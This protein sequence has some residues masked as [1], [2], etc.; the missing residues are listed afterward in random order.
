ME[1]AMRK[2]M[3]EEKRQQEEDQRRREEE[4]EMGNPQ[5]NGRAQRWTIKRPGR[6]LLY[7][8]VS[9]HLKRSRLNQRAA[10]QPVP[11]NTLSKTT[12]TT[13]HVALL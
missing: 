6:A 7:R 4:Q 3:K 5:H 1:S 8:A 2:L 12:A 10:R 9:K 13:A 11:R